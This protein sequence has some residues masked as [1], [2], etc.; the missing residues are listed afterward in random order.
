MKKIC[1]QIVVAF[2]I[3]TGF[4]SGEVKM[5]AGAG[6]LSFTGG[7][8]AG[9]G[10]HVVLL[11][12]DEEYRSEE[13][14]P[15]L[16]R[17][18]AER[19]GFDTSVLFSANAD[20]TINR[21]AT[22]SLMGAEALERAD[23]LVILVRFRNWDDATMERFKAAVGRGVPLIALRTSTHLFNFPQE[24]PWAKWS[25]NDGSGGFGKTVFGETWVSHWGDHKVEATRAVIEKGQEDNPVLNG[26]GEIFADSDV[27]EVAVPDDA[28][29][30]LRG[31]VLKGMGKHDEPVDRSKARKDGAEQKVNDPAMAVAW[32]RVVKNEEGTVNKVVTTTM[33]AATDLADESLRRLV[34]NGVYWG[35]GL[36]IPKAA[37][38]QFVGEFSPTKYG[39]EDGQNG[40][41][42]VDFVK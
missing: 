14:M 6:W 21:G 18:L 12:G 15:M 23:A 19:H 13:S 40:K 38:V 26:V 33:G 5:E 37:D 41:K 24:S 2:T 7:E 1:Q 17:I 11:A 29:V 25:W 20:G 8:G 28:T 9:K 34:V 16:A 30:L 27:Y 42:A 35:L 4:V 22:G 32:T 10:K 39:F 3:S 36:E 31:L